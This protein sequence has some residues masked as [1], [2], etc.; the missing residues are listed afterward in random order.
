MQFDFTCPFGYSAPT[1]R[2]PTLIEGQSDSGFGFRANAGIK[3]GRQT[4]FC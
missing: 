4:K 2:C 1:V 3:S